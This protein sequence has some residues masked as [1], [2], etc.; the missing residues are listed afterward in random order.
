[1][2]RTR[3]L[4]WRALI[5]LL[6]IIFG[7]QFIGG[8]FTD[9]AVK[10]WYLTLNKPPFNPPS[11][12]FG[13]VWTLLYFCIAISGWLV[14]REPPS[15]KRRRA[16]VAYSIQL[17][18]NLIWSF[19]FFYL[20]S[21]LLGL[22][23]ILLLFAAIVWTISSFWPLSKLASMLLLPYAI[24]TGYAIVLNISIYWLNRG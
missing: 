1:M 9:S 19:L 11:W 10:S 17:T 23:D 6:A 24:W 22:I 18:L 15:E 21:P 20:Q 4:K 14:V 8:M 13:P 7:I 16:L 5:A 12:L 2:K 3:P